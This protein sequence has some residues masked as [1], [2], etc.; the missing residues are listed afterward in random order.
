[1]MEDMHAPHAADRPPLP[2]Y[3][4]RPAPGRWLAARFFPPLVLPTLLAVGMY[5]GWHALYGEWHGPRLHLNLF[6]AWTPY[7]F[8][9][10]AS[11]APDRQPAGGWRIRLPGVLWLLFFPN[12]PY[13]ITDWLYLPGLTTELW[14]SIG[15]LTIFSTC[16]VLLTVVSLYLMHR[17]VRVRRGAVEGWVAVVGAVLLSGV[18][19]YLGRFLRLNS[20]DVFTD[21]L[22]VLEHIKV[23]LPEQ[24]RDVRPLGFT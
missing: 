1:M 16:G 14:Y 22:G 23:R 3:L 18:G 20:W 21:P 19:V 4:A 2:D 10:W 8:A 9:L 13:L 15:L 7:L 17:L 24:A 5:A 11:A 6:L 12:P